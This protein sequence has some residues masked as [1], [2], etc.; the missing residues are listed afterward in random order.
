MSTLQTP[1][2]TPAR[3]SQ[4]YRAAAWLLTAHLYMAAW[5]WGGVV[6]VAVLGHVFFS[7]PADGSSVVGLAYQAGVWFSFGMGVALSLRE[8][9]ANIAAGITRRAFLRANLAVAVGMG[10]VYAGAMVTLQGVEA[11]VLGAAGWEP[12]RVTSVLYDSMTDLPGLAL[13]YLLAFTAAGLAGLVVGMAYY[14]LGGVWGTIALVPAV[15]PLLGV[16]ALLGGRD[17]TTWVPAVLDPTP[18]RVL[19]VLLVAAAYG[20]VY[21]V[22]MRRVVV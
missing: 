2:S 21:R 5:F 12:R 7:R 10:A 4:A 18:T 13:V 11:L 16:L 17:G 22:L 3:R 19:V 6:V 15:P 20:A 1:R 9:E 14:R 8:L